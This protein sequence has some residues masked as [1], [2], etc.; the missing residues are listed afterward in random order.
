VAANVSYKNKTK[1]EVLRLHII[2]QVRIYLGQII[3]W[4]LTKT[5]QQWREVL[6]TLGRQKLDQRKPPNQGVS[7]QEKVFSLISSYSSRM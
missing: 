3:F 6:Y 1:S 4:L 2:S 7:Y 5:S